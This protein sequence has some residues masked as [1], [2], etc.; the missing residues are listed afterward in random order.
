MF[1]FTIIVQLSVSIADY[2]F[3]KYNYVRVCKKLHNKFVSHLLHLVVT[4]SFTDCSSLTVLPLSQPLSQSRFTLPFPCRRWHMTFSLTVLPLTQ[5]RF[6]LTLSLLSTPYDVQKLLHT[7]TS[8]VLTRR[9][10]LTHSPPSTTYDV[11][12][13]L[14]T[15]T[16]D[17]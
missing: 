13:L 7:I 4:T 11:Q 1:E 16:S 14:R 3:M 2:H 10:T 6:T 5:L 17:F 8:D 15:I 12:M 9:F